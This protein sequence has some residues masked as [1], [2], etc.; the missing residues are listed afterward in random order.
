MKDLKSTGE[1]YDYFYDK[2]N[3]DVTLGQKIQLSQIYSAAYERYIRLQEED[4]IRELFII[5]RGNHIEEIIKIKENAFIVNVTNNKTTGIF[6][7]FWSIVVDGKNL[8]DVY[9]DQESALIGL[10]CYLKS[11]N[12]LPLV[13]IMKMIQ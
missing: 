9:P 1:I 2:V 6:G 10:V 7:N 11:G 3:N 13:W 12:T 5:S 4:Q 8:S